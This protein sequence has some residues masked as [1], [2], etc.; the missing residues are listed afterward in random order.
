MVWLVEAIN[1]PKELLSLTKQI[2]SGKKCRTKFIVFEG[3]NLKTFDLNFLC[4]IR[5][6][7][8][9]LF[10]LELYSSLSDLAS[11]WDFFRDP[12]FPTPIPG[13]RDWD[14]LF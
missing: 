8:S 11:G 12:E 9:I 5:I 6:N 2:A 7:I 14:F 1:H 13:I 3:T 10:R 4:K